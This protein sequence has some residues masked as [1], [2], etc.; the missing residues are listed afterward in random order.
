MSG[1]HGIPSIEDVVLG[2]VLDDKRTR[3]GGAG[4]S[5]RLGS[6]GQRARRALTRNATTPRSFQSVV[7]RV[8]TGSTRTPQELRR[9]LDYVAREEGV[10]ATWC[11]LAG[12]DRVLAADELG[13]IVDICIDH[14]DAF[15]PYGNR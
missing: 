1:S 7:K 15:G 9:L 13:R 11:N 12:Y 10:K 6:T 14:A 5:G 4:T 2:H 8:K 3:R